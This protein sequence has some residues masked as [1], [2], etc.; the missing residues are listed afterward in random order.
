MALIRHWGQSSLTSIQWRL[1]YKPLNLIALPSSN[2]DNMVHYSSLSVSEES[3]LGSQSHDLCRGSYNGNKI[4]WLL[5]KGSD[6]K[7]HWSLYITG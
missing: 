4:L 5:R 3:F 1:G 6:S 2:H 7:K